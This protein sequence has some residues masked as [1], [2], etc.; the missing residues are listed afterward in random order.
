MTHLANL[1]MRAQGS[2]AIEM[3]LSPSASA[4]SA[5]WVGCSSGFGVHTCSKPCRC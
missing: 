1:E 5:V 4:G 2:A 3:L